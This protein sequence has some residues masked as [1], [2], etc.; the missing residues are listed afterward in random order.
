MQEFIINTFN[1]PPN[2][3]A[4]GLVKRMVQYMYEADYDPGKPSSS[5]WTSGMRPKTDHDGL[6]YTYEFQH[7]CDR[8]GVHCR[9]KTVCP[10]H[11]CGRDSCGFACAKYS[12]FQ[13]AGVV[14]PSAGGPELL[15]LHAGM[16]ALGDKYD[17]HGLPDLAKEKFESACE[18]Y[19]DTPE[20]EEVIRH[21]WGNVSVRRLMG[22]VVEIIADHASLWEKDGF[23]ELMK[24]QEGLA[25]DILMCKKRDGWR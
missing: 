17:V 3:D 19:W 13:C 1:F 12:C 8:R 5:A 14:A 9:K 23:V 24:K 16:W 7:T 11:T 6:E 15:M 4:L 10:H 2:E 20:F 22:V 21:I 18:H 25:Y